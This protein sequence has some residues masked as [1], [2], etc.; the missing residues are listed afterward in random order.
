M[1][2]VK[3]SIKMAIMKTLGEEVL[4]P[5]VKLIIPPIFCH[6]GNR[7]IQFNSLFV[8]AD[9]IYILCDTYTFPWHSK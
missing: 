1:P 6:S 2:S 3:A 9:Y 4:S 7:N 5:P 8:I